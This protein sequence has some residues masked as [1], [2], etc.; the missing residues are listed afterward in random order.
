M[1]ML[2]FTLLCRYHKSLEIFPSRFL[3]LVVV[4]ENFWAGYKKVSYLYCFTF[5][6]GTC[7]NF[8]RIAEGTSTASR[9][10]NVTS[11]IFIRVTVRVQRHRN[12]GFIPQIFPAKFDSAAPNFSGT[13][14]TRETEYGK[15]ESNR[16]GK[17][18]VNATNL[19]IYLPLLTSP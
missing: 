12:W 2:I 7:N 3:R 16:E 10:W 13:M 6:S 9:K 1:R 15:Q 17:I 19:K 4:T 18:S 5:S 11:T 8:P 14:I